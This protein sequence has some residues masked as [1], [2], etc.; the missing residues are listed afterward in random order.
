MN[1]RFSKLNIFYTIKGKF[2][3]LFDRD[4]E[5]IEISPERDWAVVLVIFLLCSL[6]LMFFFRYLFLPIDAVFSSVVIKEDA[7]LSL[8]NISKSKLEKTLAP[9]VQR[10][11]KFSEY[12]SNRPTFDFLK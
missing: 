8:G 2:K 3:S 7:E 6:S 10:E 5:K 4:A 11:K 12:F 1:N 9:W